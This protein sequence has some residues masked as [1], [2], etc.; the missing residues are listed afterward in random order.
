[1]HM[2]PIQQVSHPDDTSI[3]NL[4]CSRHYC[5]NLMLRYNLRR[6]QITRVDKK[7]PSLADI[8]KQLGCIH[9]FI[10]NN[11]LKPN[12]VFNMDETGINWGLGPTHA[13]IPKDA[14]RAGQPATDLKARITDIVTG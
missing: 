1:M 10:L 6:R 5:S 8:L 11:N 12:E 4:K 9:E 3:Q 2:I 13:W 14:N 7:L